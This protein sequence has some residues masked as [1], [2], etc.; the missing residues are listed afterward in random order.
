MVTMFKPHVFL[1][2]SDLRVDVFSLGDR[3]FSVKHGVDEADWNTVDIFQLNKWCDSFTSFVL[4]Q[5]LWLLESLF[6]FDLSEVKAARYGL[7]VARTSLYT[8]FIAAIHVV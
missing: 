6:K 1:L 4:F 7:S 5:T 8:R 3:T 2:R